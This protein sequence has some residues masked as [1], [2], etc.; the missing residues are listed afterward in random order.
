MLQDAPLPPSPY[1]ASDRCVNASTL[2]VAFEAMLLN[3][4]FVA[5]GNFS[6]NWGVTNTKEA[7]AMSSIDNARLKDCI[8]PIVAAV[9]RPPPSSP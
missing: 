3:P 4:T 8:V 1:A 7:L 9:E 2:N 5:D 6:D